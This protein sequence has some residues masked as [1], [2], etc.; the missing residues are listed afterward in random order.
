VPL[1]AAALSA[2][3]PELASRLAALG[4]LAKQEHTWVTISARNDA[5]G[6]WIYQQLRKAP[7]EHRIRAE[8]VIAGAPS[9]EIFDFATKS[10]AP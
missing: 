3:S 5:E 9:V 10:E 6:R 4:A 8:L 1:D 7:G 2:R